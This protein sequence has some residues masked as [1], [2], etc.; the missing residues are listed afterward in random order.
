MTHTLWEL[1]R[2]F[3]TTKDGIGGYQWGDTKGP[4]GNFGA[5]TLQRFITMGYAVKTGRDVR[6]QLGGTWPEISVTPAGARAIVETGI[7]LGDNPNNVLDGQVRDLKR[8][9][10]QV[11]GTYGEFEFDAETG[12][13]MGPLYGTDPDLAPM[14]ID[15][16]EWMATYPD[17]DLSEGVID[18][19]DL[20]YTT[21]TGKV[22]E[23][24]EDWREEFRANY[25]GRKSGP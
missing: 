19:L 10:A 23:P 3:A 4:D 22:E 18:I 15:V 13:V 24:V 11:R 9:K 12:A 17:D 1:A 8:P 16:E 5:E 7:L 25:V 21:F 2:I 14:R 20:G 6:N